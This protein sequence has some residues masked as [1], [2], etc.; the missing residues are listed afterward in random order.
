MMTDVNDNVIQVDFS[1]NGWSNHDI[2][3][4][5]CTLKAGQVRMANIGRKVGHNY[6]LGYAE[7]DEGDESLLIELQINQMFTQNRNDKTYPCIDV[8]N[9]LMPYGIFEQR[10]PKTLCKYYQPH[11]CE[12]EGLNI[13]SCLQQRKNELRGPDATSELLK[14]IRTHHEHCAV[15]VI[16]TY[17]KSGNCEIFVGDQTTRSTG[18]FWDADYLMYLASAGWDRGRYG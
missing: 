10:G 4:L 17:L 6:V 7:S 9:D 2:W 12:F 13:Q 1:P 14:D 15:H 3:N 16:D 18:D 5:I 11:K 8:Y